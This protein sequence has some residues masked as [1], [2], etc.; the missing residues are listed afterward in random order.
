MANIEI[1][2]QNQKIG[3]VTLDNDL[4]EIG[5]LD[6]CQICLPQPKVSS[7]HATI[8]HDSDAF[9]LQDLDSK[10]GTYINGKEKLTERY[11]LHHGDLIAIGEY[12]L[13]FISIG[14]EQKATA[15]N[16]QLTDPT[17][18]AEHTMG[19]GPGKLHTLLEDHQ[20]TD[21]INKGHA[22][23]LIEFD[24]RP[25]MKLS[26]SEIIIGKSSAADIQVG[27]WFAPKMAA[28]ILHQRDGYTIQPYKGGKVTLNDQ[29]V[30]QETRLNHDDKVS[31]Q[32]LQMTFVIKVAD[33]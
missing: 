27:G 9:Y 29:P 28:S 31:V 32:S 3:E 6:H 19:L 15:D 2:F 26:R 30:S 21:A 8:T 22:V 20:R 25:A 4:T 10:N 11:R 14:A 7:S 13:R 23:A 24:D 5:R 17:V 33:T 1:Q 18:A 12:T 16:I